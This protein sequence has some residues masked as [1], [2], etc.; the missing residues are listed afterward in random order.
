MENETVF[1]DGLYFNKKHDNAP[2]FV[3]GGLGIEVDRFVKFLQDNKGDDGR[4]SLDLLKK[5]DGTGLYFKLNTWKPEKKEDDI[6]T[7]F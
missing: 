7:P 4:V 5:K 6:E 3:K 2:D 1:A